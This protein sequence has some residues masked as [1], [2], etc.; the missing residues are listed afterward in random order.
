[1]RCSRGHPAVLNRT[2]INGYSL[3]DGQFKTNAST[4]FVTLKDFKERYSSRE[5]ALK[6]N[7]R[8][9]A[10]VRPRRGQ[11]HPDRRDHPDRASGDPGDRNDRRFRILDPGQGRP[12]IRRACTN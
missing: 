10:A 5:R 2:M 3:I 1:M 6:E 12:G 11:G 8:A 7:P 4:F 9:V